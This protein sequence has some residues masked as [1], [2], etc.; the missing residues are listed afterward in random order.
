M[1]SREE[2]IGFC[3]ESLGLSE[4]VS[5]EFFP[6]EGRGSDRAFFRL[7]WNRESSAILVHYD[8]E[9]GREHLLR[10]DCRLSA[11]DRYPGAPADPPRSCRLSHPHGRPRGYGPLVFSGNLLGE[12]DALFIRRR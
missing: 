12:I 10:R 2:M 7:K 6:L 9:A 4:S 8:P 5:M 1:K 3:R 11:G